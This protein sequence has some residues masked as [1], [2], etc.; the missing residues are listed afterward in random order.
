MLHANYITYGIIL[1]IDE[2]VNLYLLGIT[3]IY[4]YIYTCIIFYNIYIYIL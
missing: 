1:S 2:L 3:Y 4:I